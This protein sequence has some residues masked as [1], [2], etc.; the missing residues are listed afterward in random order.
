[1]AFANLWSWNEMGVMGSA[2]YADTANAGI[3]V[4]LLA[5]Y[6]LI[7]NTVVSCGLLLTHSIVIIAKKY[8]NTFSIL[9]LIFILALLVYP[10]VLIQ[11]S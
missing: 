4:A 11:F 10:L 5:I 9:N 2:P 8:Y 3:G 1:M 6:T 7:I